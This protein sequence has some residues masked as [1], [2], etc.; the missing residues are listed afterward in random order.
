MK[1]FCNSLFSFCKVFTWFWRRSTYWTLILVL[2]TLETLILGGSW[3]LYA[4][5]YL[6]TSGVRDFDIVF[7]FLMFLA[8]MSVDLV[9]IVLL[10][11]SGWS[12]SFFNV[13]SW[14]F[15][16]SILIYVWSFSSLSPSIINSMLS[17]GLTVFS[18][19][20]L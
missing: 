4:W 16:S 11:N 7:Y 8:V 18:I 17:P 10:Y 20:L 3:D 13:F 6:W 1:F 5:V 14:I 9:R 12:L 2:I 19:S 15:S